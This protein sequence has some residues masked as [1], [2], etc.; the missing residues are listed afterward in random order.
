[1]E[2]VQMLIPMEPQVFFHRLRSLMEEVMAQ[3][4]SSLLLPPADVRKE[5]PLLKA[6]EVCAIF[7]VSK[8]TVY[9]WLKKGKITSL[10]VGSRRYFHWQ[11]VEALIQRSKL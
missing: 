7:K 6:T 3:K 8:P 9:D 11:D 1:M 5:R 2:N 10:K 4:N